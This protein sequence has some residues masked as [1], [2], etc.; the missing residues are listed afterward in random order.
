MCGDALD[1]TAYHVLMAQRQAAM[2]FTEPPYD[3]P[4]DGQA[5]GP[6]RI[7]HPDFMMASGELSLAEFTAFLSQVFTLLSHYTAHGALIYTCRDWR[8]LS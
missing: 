2:V 5:S 4:I 1:E 6:G 8:H 3:V 7:R